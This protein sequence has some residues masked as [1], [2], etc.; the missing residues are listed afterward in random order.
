LNFIKRNKFFW[1][2]WKMVIGYFLYCFLL[3][4]LFIIAPFYLWSTAGI[5]ERG[6]TSI[7]G[8]SMMPTIQD[9]SIMYVQPVQYERGEVVVVRCPEIMEYPITTNLAL[10]KRIVGLPGET[11]EIVEEGILIDGVLLDEPY[12]ADQTKTLSDDNDINEIILSD[13]EY[14]L[15]GDNRADSFDSRHVGAIHSADFLYGL[16][17]TPNAHTHKL[18]FA[19]GAVAIVNTAIVLGM[20]LNLFFFLTREAIVSEP[21][22]IVVSIKESNPDKEHKP[23]PMSERRRRKQKN[24]LK[25]QKQLMTSKK[26]K[27]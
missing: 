23:Q 15:L 6:I 12:A 2:Q 8:S 24:L 1:K 4:F 20:S 17:T 7:R 18:M 22:S 10:L 27:K 26:K 16:T 25:K 9:N 14:F 13:N 11:I 3:F 5:Q 19:F 21:T